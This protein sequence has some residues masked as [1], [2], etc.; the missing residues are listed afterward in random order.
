MGGFEFGPRFNRQLH[1]LDLTYSTPPLRYGAV[2]Y[3]RIAFCLSAGQSC[4]FH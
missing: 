4:A 3:G 2:R 1:V